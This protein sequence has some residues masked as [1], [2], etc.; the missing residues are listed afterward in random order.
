MDGATESSDLGPADYAAAAAALVYSHPRLGFCPPALPG[1]KVDELFDDT[2]KRTG[3]FAMSLENAERASLI[4]A[5][6]GTNELID[7]GSAANMAISQ[8]LPNRERLLTCIVKQHW[9]EIIICGH[10]L[11]GGLAQYLAYDAV[12]T[13]PALIEQITVVTF[14]GIGGRYGLSRLYEHPDPELVRRIRFFHYA[15]PDDVICR[16]GGNLA[17]FVYLLPDLDWHLPRLSIAHAI[18]QFLPR[19]GHS[20]LAGAVVC[21]D[22]P[23]NL[24]LSARDLGPQLEIAVLAMARGKR[25][26]AICRICLLFLAIPPSERLQVLRFVL[27]LTPIR[28]IARRTIRAYYFL[29]RALRRFPRI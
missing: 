17:D 24:A 3:F 26:A 4:L 25:M 2:E 12:C 14:N 28:S 10:S 6:C 1:Y 16:I 23:F 20:T 15:H 22:R 9:Q 7:L 27:S 13:H 18:E 5:F 11:G 19:E 8:Y 29:R 21:P